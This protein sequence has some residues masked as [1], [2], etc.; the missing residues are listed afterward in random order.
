MVN[1]KKIF[2]ARPG[3]INPGEGLGWTEAFLLQREESQRL[4]GTSSCW[5]VYFL[6]GV[7][8]AGVST[9]S[10][11]VANAPE[12]VSNSQLGIPFQEVLR[13]KMSPSQDKQQVMESYIF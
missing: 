1:E 7:S 11:L 4:P 12:T 3:G 9:A 13:E 8:F 2:T 10:C 6:A 5:D